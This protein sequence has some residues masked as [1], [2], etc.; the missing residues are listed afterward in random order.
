MWILVNW[1]MLVQSCERLYKDVVRS[2]H[3]I[4]DPTIHH[5]TLQEILACCVADIQAVRD[6]DPACTSFLTCLMYFKGFQALQC[7]RVAHWMWCNGRQVGGVLGY[8]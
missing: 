6:R 8:I 3:Y 7:H 1:V 2:A 5:C 4:S